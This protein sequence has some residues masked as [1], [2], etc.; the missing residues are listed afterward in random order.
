MVRLSAWV[1]LLGA[2]S[3]CSALPE[4]GPSSSQDVDRPT[5][6]DDDPGGEEL[7]NT[8]TLVVHGEINDSPEDCRV[9]VNL[10]EELDE[11]TDVGGTG[12]K[13]SLD[14]GE[15][16]VS[17]GDAR[18]TSLAGIPLHR[19]DE[20]FWIPENW[21]TF[22]ILKDRI[23]EATIELVPLDKHR[24]ES[25]QCPWPYSGEECNIPLDSHEQWIV[26]EDGLL[27]GSEHDCFGG[28]CG[29]ELRVDDAEMTAQGMDS[30]EVTELN[31]NEFT[32][33]FS[34]ILNSDAAQFAARVSC[35]QVP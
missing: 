25:W 4:I 28:Q 5:S 18:T 24:C 13:I 2:P 8:G 23:T 9:T 29:V 35:E 32:H 34:Y 33:D 10:P 1:F 22:E 3:G 16:V 11:W 27:R 14:P 15:Y 26:A 21:G 12:E 31:Y 30:V 17:V 7:A 20:G 6:G 19:N